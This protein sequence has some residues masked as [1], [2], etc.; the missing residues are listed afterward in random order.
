M[1]FKSSVLFAFRLIFPRSAK[2]SSARR[3]IFGA[4]LCIGI[5]LVPLVLV[6]SFSEGMIDG[7]TERLIGLSSGELKA[8]L[9]SS[10][11]AASS[12]QALYDYSKLLKEVDGVQ[13]AFLQI[14]CM[15][16]ASG[17]S[18]RVGTLVRAVESDIFERNGD[19][20]S[21]LKVKKGSLTA[22]KNDSKSAII[23]EK[24]ADLLDLNPGDKIRLI[25]TRTLPNGSISPLMKTF[26]VAAVVSSGYQELDSMWIFIP[27]EKAFSILPKSS[28]AYSVMLDVKGGIKGNLAQ[29]KEECE[30]KSLGI[31]RISLWQTLNRSRLENFSSTKVML[32]FIMLLIVLVASVNI[33]S[34]LVMLVME[35]RKEI[36]ILK[37]IGASSSGITISFL[38][39]GL[40][41]GFAGSLIGLPLGLLCAVNSN[42]IISALE[43]LVN[44]SAKFFYILS[45]SQLSAFQDIHLLNPDYYLTEIPINVPYSELFLIASAVL[46]LS[47]LVSVIPA[48]KAGLER[49]LETFRKA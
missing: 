12:Y 43:H 20:A 32:T 16:L 4:I 13:D 44:F 6:M 2:K 38:I 10:A 3:S 5:S 15:A 30:K 25:F 48:I 11:K 19:F 8:Q 29:I 41:C 42:Q 35:R 17:S 33:S 49:P 34:A 39:A 7:M 22:F 45:G 36:A 31:A 47:L 27:I 46:I 9:R 1:T 26:T 28:S 23:G 18:S 40:S 14:E 21:L 37:S 24:I